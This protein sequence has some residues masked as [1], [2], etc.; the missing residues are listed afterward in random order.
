[1]EQQIPQRRAQRADVRSSREALKLVRPINRQIGTWQ[2]TVA[3]LAALGTR[4]P[5]ADGL[6][7]I[8]GEA[9]RLRE[10]VQ[11]EEQALAQQ[12]AL[13][14]TEVAVNGRLA[15]TR[16][17]INTVLAGC[18]RVLEIVSAR[19]GTG[20]VPRPAVHAGTADLGR[21]LG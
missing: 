17:A 1:M 21:L 5:G 20:A 8:E 16:N 10:L 12:I 3:R 15:D 14:P 6:H 13:L 9:K 11:T 2:I 4:M 7:T 19:K 18:E